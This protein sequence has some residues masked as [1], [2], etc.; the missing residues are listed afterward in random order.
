MD[1]AAKRFLGEH[2][3]R[4][5]CKVSV[6]AKTYYLS[7]YLSSNAIFSVSLCMYFSF[8]M[9]VGNNVTSFIRNVLSAKVERIQNSERFVSEFFH[10]T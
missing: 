7:F 10:F 1:E 4:N 6:C 2:D 8:K 3:F 9:D 5:F